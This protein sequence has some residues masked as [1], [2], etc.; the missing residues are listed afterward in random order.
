[1]EFSLVLRPDADVDKALGV[2]QE[3]LD[4]VEA[5]QYSP[6]LEGWRF[7]FEHQVVDDFDAVRTVSSICQLEE[8][9]VGYNVT[10][11]LQLCLA[12]LRLATTRS[13]KV[14]YDP[15]PKRAIK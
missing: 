2:F 7:Q 5:L 4:K 13:V 8:L 12:P 10:G 1:M 11:T 6:V 14:N 15:Q 3:E 9:P